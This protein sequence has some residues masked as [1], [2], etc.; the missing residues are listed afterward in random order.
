MA[1]GRVRGRVAYVVA[2]I[3][4]VQTRDQVARRV[5][6]VEVAPPP[7]CLRT[8]QK[9]SLQPFPSPRPALSHPTRKIVQ[10]C[11]IFV[12]GSVFNRHVRTDHPPCPKLTAIKP[13]AG[14]PLF[15]QII[16]S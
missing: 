5:D 3:G 11:R 4:Q 6:S 1:M 10:K 7:D 8:R 16:L 13:R 12:F 9:S 2:V 14:Q 15:L